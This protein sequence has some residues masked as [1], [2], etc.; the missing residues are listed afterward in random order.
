MTIYVVKYSINL[1]Q[2]HKSNKKIVIIVLFHSTGFRKG[3][4]ERSLGKVLSYINVLCGGYKKILKKLRYFSPPT[5]CFYENVLSSIIHTILSE[6]LR[7]S[8]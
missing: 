2:L 5:K 7:Q 8:L 4:I 1:Y 3:Y 6:P